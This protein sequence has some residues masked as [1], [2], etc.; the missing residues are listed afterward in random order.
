MRTIS[1]RS[2]LVKHSPIRKMSFLADK[3]E[4]DIVSFYI[5][6]PDFTTPMN[7]IEA[8]CDALHRGETHYAPNAGFRELRNAVAKSYEPDGVQYDPE[9]EIAV[10]SGGMQ[11]LNLAFQSTVDEGVEVIVSNPC[12]PN[13]IE[14]IKACGGT[15]VPV[16][17]YE[18]DGFVFNIENLRKAVTDKTK[19]IVINTPCNPT[20]GVIR[21]NVLK[22][23]ANL[24]TEKDLWVLS[25]EVY[26]HFNYTGEYI[27]TI[28]SIQEM[29]ERTIIINSASK[30]YAM[31]G[32]R[33]GYVLGPADLVASVIKFQEGQVSSVNSA[34]QF[35]AIEALEGTQE[36]LHQM[37]EVYQR[38]RDLLIDG[39]NSIDKISCIKP[40]GAFYV[41][42]NIMETGLSSWEFAER[43]LDEEKVVVVPGV[44]F[45]S[46]GE[47]FVRLAYAISEENIKEGVKR[48]KRFVGSL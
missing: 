43:L 48:I 10:T 4:G 7:I 42:T 44:G 36:P 33:V 16:P 29:K 6:E 1:K 21:T 32:W 17:V 23:I 18:E 12:F 27:P 19:M 20:G 3:A 8:A 35:G 15:P 30:A 2:K 11:A 24:A 34:A 46:A 5:G 40:S 22:Q 41:F 28:A 14:Q 47:G 13:Y 37:I 38:R 45:G 31:T 9:T 26:K 25:D 39:L